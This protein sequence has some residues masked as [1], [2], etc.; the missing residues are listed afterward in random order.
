MADSYFRWSTATMVFI[1]QDSESFDI[2]DS[3]Y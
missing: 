3:G 1:T 2:S